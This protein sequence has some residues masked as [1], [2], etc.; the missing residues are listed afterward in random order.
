MD[1]SFDLHFYSYFANAI[2]EPA[3][4]GLPCTKSYVSFLNRKSFIQRIHPILTLSLK[5]H[6]KLIF[7]LR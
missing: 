3:L 5:F 1:E 6:D 4:Y 7:F 2:S